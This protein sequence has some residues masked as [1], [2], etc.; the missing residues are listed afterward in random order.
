MKTSED[1]NQEEVFEEEELPLPEGVKLAPI[2]FTTFVLS[3]RETCMIQ[4]G[5]VNDGDSKAV[6]LGMARHTIE[7]LEL[8]DRKTRGNLTGDE[9][10]VLSHVIHELRA[11]YCAKVRAG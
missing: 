8:L 7:I 2:D 10:R 3:L 6:D 4:L 5:E 11:C 1:D 9:E